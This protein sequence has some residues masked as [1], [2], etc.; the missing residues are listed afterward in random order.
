[1]SVGVLM[2]VTIV[3]FQSLRVG[4]AMPDVARKLGGLGGVLVALGVEH[5][6]DIGSAPAAIVVGAGAATAVRLLASRRV[7]AAG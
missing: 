4:T 6:W 1:M 3:A 5:G 2:S 7:A